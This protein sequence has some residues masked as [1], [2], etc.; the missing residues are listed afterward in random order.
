M[1]QLTDSDFLRAIGVTP[2]EP[3]FF[4]D[5]IRA[6]RRDRVI[7]GFAVLQ[8]VAMAAALIWTAV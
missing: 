4:D 7:Q 5:E 1:T 8:L 6:R 2:Y 3:E